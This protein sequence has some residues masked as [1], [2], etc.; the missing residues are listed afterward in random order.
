[1][2]KKVLK[3]LKVVLI[4]I[5]AFIGIIVLTIG[6]AVA[7]E[8]LY[9]II[10]RGKVVIDI[11]MNNA[12]NV[13]MDGEYVTSF[14]VK[15]DSGNDIKICCNNVTVDSQNR[16]AMHEGGYIYIA[17]SVN[18][19][20][21]VDISKVYGEDDESA[22]EYYGGYGADGVTYDD[23]KDIIWGRGSGV[24]TNENLGRFRSKLITNHYA[25]KADSGTSIIESLVVR[26]SPNKIVK[27]FA[28][29]VFDQDY[30]SAYAEGDM[31]DYMREQWDPDSGLLSFYIVM[32][33][34]ESK[35]EKNTI[36]GTY[37][38][39][40][41]DLYDINGNIKDK[42]TE[43]LEKGDS[44]CVV[45]AGNEYKVELP[46]Y[47]SYKAKN[48][49]ELIPAQFYHSNG[50]LNVVVVPIC[51]E[52]QKELVSEDK[53]NN[54]KKALGR[55]TDGNTTNIYAPDDQN[56]YSLSD[57]F[58]NVSLGQQKITSYVTDW[59]VV[60]G[61][62]FIDKREEA[63]TSKDIENISKWLKD[64][65]PELGSE[66][67]VDGDGYY[68]SVI[69]LC[70]SPDEEITY[71]TRNTYGGAACRAEAY[72]SEN[73][74][75]DMTSINRYVLI[76]EFMLYENEDIYS[77]IMDTNILIHEMSHG[78]GLIDYYDVLSTGIDAV[79]FYDMQSENAGDW[80]SYSKFSVGWVTPTVVTPA[81][82]EKEKTIDISIGSAATTGDCIVIPTEK[83]VDGDGIV[84]PFA[85]YIMI[86]YY[87]PDGVNK[88]D[89]VRFGIDNTKGVRIYHIDSRMIKRELYDSNHKNYYT[90]GSEVCNNAYDAAG[91]YMVE[92]IQKPGVNT[93]TD[94]DNLN[95]MLT[96]DDLFYTGDVFSMDK[97]SSFFINGKMDDGSDINYEI[98]IVST[99]GDEATIRIKYTSK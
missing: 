63:P 71:F 55:V 12:S 33:P 43:G 24:R 45:L 88:K 97:H 69:I 86:D 20:N 48:Y 54:I 52:D 13:V 91:K 98:E 23:Y 80:N 61:Q 32:T 87:T 3:V 92:L 51:F 4:V 21:Y 42:Y 85:E 25:I 67:D 60:K 19:I 94:L 62:Y 64:N 65:Y 72:G 90:I 6:G 79:G 50:D 10:G 68:D 70:A 37:S 36:T 56:E 29:V 41:K 46:I 30:Y 95:V 76:N 74:K 1:M 2:M 99:G 31:Y 40:V 11:S 57:Y 47:E 84:S 14:T 16:L 75:K 9:P 35:A 82:I 38:F 26:Y 59:Y 22:I 8:Q 7:Y 18:G 53:L 17:D 96:K 28:D 93:F 34:A 66:Y 39:E 73:V 15:D 77:G 5:A 49:K 89:S 44:I 78:Y 58:D 27:P 81:Q 83:Y